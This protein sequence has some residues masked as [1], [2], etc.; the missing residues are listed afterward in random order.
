MLLTTFLCLNSSRE[1]SEKWLKIFCSIHTHLKKED[2]HFTE[3]FYYWSHSYKAQFLRSNNCWWRKRRKTIACTICLAW[4]H[5][6]KLLK[7]NIIDDKIT[8]TTNNNQNQKS[9]DTTHKKKNA[10]SFFEYVG[11]T[12]NQQFYLQV[13]MRLHDA[14]WNVRL[15]QMVNSPWK[16]TMS[17]NNLYKC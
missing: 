15:Q 11:Q 5:R 4:K 9:L 13:L 12:I 1:K 16:C 7:D 3:G 6:N 17:V 10:N 2:K 8:M 14:H